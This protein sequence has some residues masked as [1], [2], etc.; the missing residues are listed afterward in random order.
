MNANQTYG[1]T[2][3]YAHAAGLS[4][5]S[6]YGCVTSTSVPSRRSQLDIS[7]RVISGVLLGAAVSPG[8][9][10]KC[11]QEPVV[12]ENSC[13]QASAPVTTPHKIESIRE[14]FGLTTS[15]LAEILGVSRPTIYQWIRGQ[16]D[17]SG[18]NKARL[19]RV[20]LIAARWSKAFPT[21]NMDHWLTDNEPGQASLMDLL[22]QETQDSTAMD[23]LMSVRIRQAREA[24]Q[25][26][27]AARKAAGMGDLP[28]PEGIVPEN[29]YRW[30]VARMSMRRSAKLLR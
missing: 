19:D 30:N 24:D 10:V 16:S 5:E 6:F 9:I 22:R 3:D 1:L 11:Q 2:T 4:Y 12:I 14:A 20:A 29:I 18:D 15:A 21:M 7:A 17:P 23:R 27:A 13:Q 28:P 8:E 25:R 26:I